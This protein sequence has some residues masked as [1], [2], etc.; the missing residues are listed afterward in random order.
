MS[1]SGVGSEYDIIFAGGGTV[2]CVAAGRLAEADPS[3]RILLIEQGPHTRNLPAHIHP[4]RFIANLVPTSSVFTFHVAQPSEALLG[5][6]PI[7][8]AGRCVG[9]GSSVNFMVY[10]RAAA[11]DYDD[12]ET[13][14]GNTG[15]GSKDLI[16]LL[17]KVETY[18]DDLSPREEGMHG[19][20]GPIKV[21]F[22][23]VAT[24]VGKQFMETARAYDK[25]HGVTVDSN[26][27]LTINAYS[28]WMKYIDAKSGKRSDAAHHFI[29][30]QESADSNL[31][32][33]ANAAVHRIIIKEHR[34]IG[35]EYADSSDHSSKLNSVYAK[36]LVVVSAG[37]F[38]SPAILQRSGIG[39]SQLLKKLD[40]NEQVDLPGVGENYQDHNLGFAT[41]FVPDCTETLDVFSGHLGEDELKSYVDRWG[42]HGDGLLAT[43][44]IDAGIKLR[45]NE[46][47]LK[48]LGPNFTRIWNN[49][50]KDAPDKPVM[51]YVPFASHYGPV[52]DPNGKYMSML[53][54]PEYPESIG[55]LHITS[56]DDWR[57][58]L[59]FEP[60]YLT[61]SADLDILRWA[62]KRSREV[63][64]RMPLYRGEV[65]QGHPTF[66][67][68]SEAA[69][70]SRDGPVPVDAP[71]IAYTAEDNEAIH[72]FLRN[73]VS[74]TW[75]SM[76]T[77]AMKPRDR[78]GVVDSRLN[79]YGMTN[80]KVAELSICPSNVSANTYNT[81][82]G[83]GE[84]AAVIIADDL[85][86]KLAV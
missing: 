40:I 31:H 83:I 50:Y 21:S 51:M 15:W 30:N 76:G 66:S 63:A 41:Y 17:Q 18:Q 29:Y 11:S 3:L 78:G 81:A 55:R 71:D 46:D 47:D 2:A 33:L 14:H 24:E 74:T 82:L 77:C 34:A 44:G 22:G 10:T 60:G 69:C 70:V 16:P 79:V 35:V 38:G 4:A 1:A 57:Q 84:K 19:D 32:V 65:Q 45:P 85:G 8:P 12:W 26:D 75:H 13:I 52:P 62:Y 28:R 7:V 73:T 67:P 42:Q 36:K 80:L 20:S 6:A 86:I 23:G 27:F 64:R 5:R 25:K 56:G 58:P 37:A 43:N 61:E 72:D 39:A 59:Y 68:N 54:F 48:E 53:W 49:Y 9:G